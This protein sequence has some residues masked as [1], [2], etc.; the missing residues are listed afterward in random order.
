MTASCAQFHTLEFLREVAHLRAR[1]NVMGAMLRVR[2]AAALA[3]H[4]FFDARGYVQVHTP[5]LTSN[6]CEGAGETF[7]VAPAADVDEALK[8]AR[9]GA[10]GEG[11][12][13]PEASLRSF[14]G[15]QAYLTVGSACQVLRAGTAARRQPHHAPPRSRCRASCRQRCLRAH[16]PRC[17]RSVPPSEQRFASPVPPHATQPRLRA[18]P[19][20]PAAMRAL[21]EL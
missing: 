18:S 14:F 6:D 19:K 10:P 11:D 1:T 2:S 21:P 13:S 5:V 7:S 15:R 16:C 12:L 3:I 17:T 9:T 20:G 8:R 4:S